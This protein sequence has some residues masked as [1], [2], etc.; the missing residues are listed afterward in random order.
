MSS[1]HHNL[2]RNIA[3]APLA[4]SAPKVAAKRPHTSVI[5]LTIVSGFLSLVCLFG[6]VYISAWASVRR[7]G[8]RRVALMKKERNA[9]MRLQEIKSEFDRTVSANEIDKKAR[10]YDMVPAN[11][12][13]S[14][15]IE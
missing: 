2:A 12:E 6:L 14:V 9:Q 3:L 5:A 7:E 11:E 4:P 1:N 8:N 13:K 10:A 15:V